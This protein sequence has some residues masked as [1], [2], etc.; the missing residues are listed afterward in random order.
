MEDLTYEDILNGTADKYTDDLIEEINKLD[1]LDKKRELVKKEVMDRF[2]SFCGQDNL[3]SDAFFKSVYKLASNNPEFFT[4]ADID[5]IFEKRRDTLWVP[6]TEEVG[7]AIEALSTDELRCDFARIFVRVNEA[8]RVDPTSE[9][10]SWGRVYEKSAEK[11][12]YI[13]SPYLMGAERDLL[14]NLL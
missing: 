13:L 10:H 9:S 3:I 2:E 8:F 5:L 7:A 14:K 6:F 12:F 4:S 11:I 1:S